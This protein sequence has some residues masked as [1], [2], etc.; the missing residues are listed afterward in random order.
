LHFS[1]CNAEPERLTK[2]SAFAD[3]GKVETAATELI[4][5]QQLVK[6]V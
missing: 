4:L 1:V 3:G 6:D 5:F 2:A